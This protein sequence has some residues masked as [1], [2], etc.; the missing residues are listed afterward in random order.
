[1]L[2]LL[3]QSV[4]PLVHPATVAPARADRE[5]Y[6]RYIAAFGD[7]GLLCLQQDSDTNPD[8]SPQKAPGQDLPQ[9]PICQA[10]H[11]TAGYVPPDAVL[12]PVPSGTAI[13]RATAFV[14]TPALQAIVLDGRPRG[15]PLA[16][17]SQTLILA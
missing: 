8:R 16:A 3:L 9:C 2:A 15:P 1:M 11:A 7:H 6:A 5:S 17:L 13:A 14:D 12:L 10:L 4:V